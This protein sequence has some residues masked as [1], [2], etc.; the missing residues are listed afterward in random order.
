KL[1][2]ARKEGIISEDEF[3]KLKKRLNILND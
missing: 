1:N 3:N 2:E